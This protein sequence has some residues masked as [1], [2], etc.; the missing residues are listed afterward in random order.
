VLTPERNLVNVVFTPDRLEKSVATIV[1]DLSKPGDVIPSVARWLRILE[2]NQ[3]ACFEKLRRKQPH[4]ADLIQLKSMEAWSGGGVRHPDISSVH[5]MKLPIIIVATK[6]DLFKTTVESQVRKAV[7]Q[8]L[9][10]FAHIHGATLLCSSSTDK[11]LL[12]KFTAV[13]SSH[14]FGAKPVK[15]L[16]MDYNKPL[17]IPAG[18]DTLERI[19]GP[20]GS[21]KGSM[22]GMGYEE[23]L[24][25]WRH[26]VVELAKP[27][28]EA[29]GPRVENDNE[30]QQYRHP[31]IDARRI[32]KEEELNHYRREVERKIKMATSSSSD[33]KATEKK[34]RPRVKAKSSE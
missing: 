11:T 8:A 28:E 3:H 1:V 17:M 30:V 14:V 16:E 26:S 22:E 29:E 15:A 33:R 24:R 23:Q 27:S 6:Y 31:A 25:A 7:L 13:L 20:K 32:E 5:M 10:F 4:V 12:R 21:L 2:E 18:M 19:G 34:S 9:R